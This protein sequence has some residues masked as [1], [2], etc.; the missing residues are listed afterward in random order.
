MTVLLRWVVSFLY[1]DHAITSSILFLCLAVC[2]FR[3]PLSI[4]LSY[5]PHHLSPVL[6]FTSPL[7][8]LS[9]PSRNLRLCHSSLFF[10]FSYS[11]FSLNFHILFPNLSSL[12]SPHI[13]LS[14]LNV[15]PTFSPCW[16]YFSLLYTL[17][18]RLSHHTLPRCLSFI[19][20]S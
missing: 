9:L 19:H 15:Y 2:L 5:F 20:F 3:S 14:F 8:Y 11:S 4:P 1:L 13:S 12:V 16:S 10:P 17:S 18:L 6:L 7:P